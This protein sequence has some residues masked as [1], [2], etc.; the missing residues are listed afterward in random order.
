MYLYREIVQVRREH[1]D[2]GLGREE[3]MKYWI[4]CM[5][6]TYMTQHETL[7]THDISLSPYDTRHIICLHV[8]HHASHIIHKSC[9]ISHHI[10]HSTHKY[11]C[12]TMGN[13]I[14]GDV[15]SSLLVATSSH[16]SNANQNI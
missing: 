11:T 12:N 6:D 8:T 2:D 5:H 16:T 15:V 13:C 4:S 10:I 14:G 7:I 9:L 1:D 3:P